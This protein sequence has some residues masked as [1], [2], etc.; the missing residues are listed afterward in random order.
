MPWLPSMKSLPSPPSSMSAP[1]LPRIVSLPAPPSTVSLTIPAASVDAVT[2][3]LPPRA[4]TTSESLAPSELVIVHQGRQPDHG[5]R[6][7]RAEDVDDVVA[8]GAVDDDGVGLAVARRRR[9][10]R[11][12]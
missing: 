4:L 3:S 5:G 8:V 6:G 9:A 11:P 10:R 12:G 2:P 7:P 1:R